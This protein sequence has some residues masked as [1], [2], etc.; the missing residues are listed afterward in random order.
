MVSVKNIRA[1]T[2]DG[3]SPGKPHG[4][5]VSPTSKKLRSPGGRGQIVGGFPAKKGKTWRTLVPEEADDNEALW[6]R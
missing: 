4:F 5:T 1:D 2:C 6:Y 3:K